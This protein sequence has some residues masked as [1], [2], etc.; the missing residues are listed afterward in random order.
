MEDQQIF[1]PS[2][3]VGPFI[4]AP[5]ELAVAERENG[6]PDFSIEYIRGA[7]PQLPPVPYGV[8]D[9]RLKTSHRAEEA[10]LFLR[11]TYPNA[12][13]ATLTFAS[14]FL[15]LL[16][17]DPADEATREFRIPVP[18]AWNDLGRARSII[19]LSQLGVTMLKR[20][21]SEADLLDI[22]AVAEMEFVGMSPRVPATVQFD[23]AQLIGKLVT[24]A[25]EERRIARQTL[26]SYFRQ[27]PAAI[28][29]T[30]TSR[31]D[32]FTPI[33]FAEAMTDHVRMRFGAFIPSPEALLTPCMALP[34][35]E[36]IG[37]GRFEWDLSRSIPVR[38]ALVLSFDPI[39]QARN[40]T[41]SKGL[42]AVFRET[43]VPQFQTG[44]HRIDIRANIPSP[45]HGVIAVGVTLRAA[46]ILPMRPQTIVRS[47]ELTP[48]EDVA[49][50]WLPLA[51]RESLNYTYA[52][53]AV[54]DGPTGGRQIEAVERTSQKNQLY[55]DPE[56]FPIKFLSI[57]ADPQLLELAEVEGICRWLEGETLKHLTFQLTPACST[58]AIGLPRDAKEEA[59]DIE[60]RELN[61]GRSLH[62]G[63][64]STPALW[65]GLHS[66]REYG[67]HQI[68]VV[69]QLNDGEALVAVDLQA[70]GQINSEDRFEVLS[71]TRTTPRREWS[72]LASS[73][74]CSGYRYRMHASTNGLPGPWSEIRSPFE[75]LTV[76][77]SG[78]GL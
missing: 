5:V 52:T 39:E 71:L 8:L 55:L 59:L 36:E 23:P 43:I 67:L 56:D 35:R 48:P 9:F 66:F 70:E 24:L 15:R 19:R 21:L 77:S 72:Y 47:A 10:L 37:T 44:T 22:R 74:F 62:L 68:P 1:F 65:L 57:E 32:A 60:A 38:R 78:S 73:P 41:A 50:I 42:D 46:P 29:L 6:A 75:A 69:C 17:G 58:V 30:L 34:S 63:P 14:G 45:R 51:A 28:G 18:L 12:T 27:D 13:A 20:T 26:L 76:N 11:R 33:E 61:S 64:L 49:S 7:T 3:G 16:V 54:L 40:I 25:D 2:D 4:L 53:F 31:G